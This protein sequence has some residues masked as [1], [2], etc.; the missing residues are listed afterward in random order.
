MSGGTDAEGDTE[1][2]RESF[3]RLANDGLRLLRFNVVILGLYLTGVGLLLR[4]ADTTMQL[5]L[6]RSYW[7]WVGAVGLMIALGFSAAVYEPSRTV[8]VAPLYGDR[9][10]KVY[11]MM[12]YGTALLNL[13]LALVCMLVS[14]LSLAISLFDALIPVRVAPSVVG[15]VVFVLLLVMA[16]ARYVVQ[17]IVRLRNALG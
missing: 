3:D 16:G 1:Q 14:G 7:L 13:R 15:G 2:I 6:I 17:G 11:E 10:S 8:S 9:E 12:D 5:R 4:D